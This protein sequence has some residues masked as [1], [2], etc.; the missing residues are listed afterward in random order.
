MC[1]RITGLPCQRAGFPHASLASSPPAAAV[2]ATVVALALYLVRDV[3]RKTLSIPSLPL[4]CRREA[5]PRWY[6]C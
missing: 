4:P 1:T 6:F 5:S 3:L 2:V